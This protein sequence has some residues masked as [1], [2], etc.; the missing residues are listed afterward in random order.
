M[1]VKIRAAGLRRAADRKV[2]KS[3]C[4]DVLFQR[5]VMVNEAPGTASK[6][7]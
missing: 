1:G 5:R 2:N 6:C 3:K 7:R 4:R